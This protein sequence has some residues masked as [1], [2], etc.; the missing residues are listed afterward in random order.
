MLI[1][2]T[3]YPGDFSLH[4]ILSLQQMGFGEQIYFAIANEMGGHAYGLALGLTASIFALYMLDA[5]EW[6]SKC[7]RIFLHMSIFVIVCG[8]AL[9]ALLTADRFPYGTICMFVILY[10]VWLLALKL[11]FYDEKDTRVFVSWLSGPLLFT[12]VMIGVLWITWVFSDPDNE[13]NIVARMVAAERTGCE[14]NYE[15]Y[16]ECRKEAGSEESC[17]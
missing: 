11:I 17:F 16:P 14:P 12:S 8:F 5:D 4:Y 7:G 15:T 6:T 9:L 13:W 1:H 3:F 2:Y 10:P